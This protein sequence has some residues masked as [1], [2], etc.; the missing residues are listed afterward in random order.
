LISDNVVK[1]I[2]GKAYRRLCKSS[3]VSSR[4]GTHVY[5]DIETDIALFRV[6]ETIHAVTNICPHKREPAIFDGF[7]QDGTVVC[8]MH[9]WCFDIRTGKNTS[10]GASLTVYPILEHDGWVWL[11][12][13]TVK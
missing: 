8:P 12:I 1:E 10:A 7:V 2:N 11:E 6:E 4:R 3:A 5:V 9:G 13:Q